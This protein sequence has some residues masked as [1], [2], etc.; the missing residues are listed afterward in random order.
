[1]EVGADVSVDSGGSGGGVS[2]R[3]MRKSKEALLKRKLLKEKK[4]SR[5][6]CVW[7]FYYSRLGARVFEW[8]EEGLKIVGKKEG[9][10]F[11]YRLV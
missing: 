6:W 8:R 3:G 9:K 11:V 1:M 4:L 10:D 7:S 5:N 2:D